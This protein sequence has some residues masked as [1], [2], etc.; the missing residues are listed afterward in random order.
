MRMFSGFLVFSIFAPKNFA[1]KMASTPF[2]T[3]NNGSGAA[4][5]GAVRSPMRQRSSPYVGPQFSM[6][7]S[8]LPAPISS[9]HLRPDARRATRVSVTW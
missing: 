1:R 5:P 9:S 8:R 3:V 6:V 4:T 7:K 2:L